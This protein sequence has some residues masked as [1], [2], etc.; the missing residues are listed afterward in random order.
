MERAAR[1]KTA[2]NN[3]GQVIIEA[4]AVFPV[5][6]ALTI[7]ILFSTYFVIARK[8]ADYWVYRAALCQATSTLHHS[9]RSKLNEKLT[10]VMPN[11][12]YHLESTWITRQE[13]HVAIRI[14][15][16]DYFQMKVQSRVRLP[17][18]RSTNAVL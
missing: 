2:D 14:H 5:L 6:V 4:L 8:W 7:L 16:S 13:S 1:M 15:I 10:F 12:F 18:G 17:L 3:R 11:S 9:C